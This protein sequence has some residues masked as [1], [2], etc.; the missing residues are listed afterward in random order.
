MHY[1]NTGIGIF[2]TVSFLGDSIVYSNPMIRK[3]YNFGYNGVDNISEFW[4]EN[5]SEIIEYFRDFYPRL[6]K[7]PI[8]LK[9][10]E[11]EVRWGSRLGMYIRFQIRKSSRLTDIN[12]S[13]DLDKLATKYG[14]K[15]YSISEFS[16]LN[17][18]PEGIDGSVDLR[19][20]YL[21]KTEFKY[22]VI[23]NVD[24]SYAAFDC[25]LFDNVLFES[26]I[27]IET[28]FSNG[29]IKNCS[30]DKHCVFENNDFSCTYIDGNFNSKIINP[31][32]T[33]VKLWKLIWIKRAK[34][35]KFLRYT[36]V[37]SRT[38]ITNCK[39]FKTQKR[40]TL[41]IPYITSPNI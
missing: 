31:K 35:T 3:L 18:I 10:F 30:F 9:K 22:L 38:F 2:T 8:I 27:F 16:K 12:T 23:R 39:D 33:K 13:F 26:C 1:L 6:L 7:D 5:R 17:P 28:S 14:S 34:E 29:V 19:G 15:Y 41:T 20:I 4:N 11:L 36:K 37:L 40:L 21:M 25:T 24:F 32:I